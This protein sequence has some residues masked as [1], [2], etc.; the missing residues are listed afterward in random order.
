MRPPPRASDEVRCR[1]GNFA[2]SAYLVRRSQELIIASGDTPLSILGLCEQLR[3]SRRTRQNSFQAVTGMRLVEY[4]RNLRLN[5]V[6]RRLI[7]TRSSEKNVGEIA[8]SM[9]FFT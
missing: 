6:R 9:A 8:V 4:L 2:V 1:R 7:A 5:A 3:V